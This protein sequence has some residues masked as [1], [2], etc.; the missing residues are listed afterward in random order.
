MTLGI[1]NCCMSWTW[2]LIHWALNG[3]WTRLSS[4]MSH[5]CPPL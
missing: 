5:C 4:K 3:C 2:T 1:Y